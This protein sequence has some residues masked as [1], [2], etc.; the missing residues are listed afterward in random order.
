MSP[1]TPILDD[2][3]ADHTNHYHLV[4]S[5][6]MLCC[7]ILTISS[8]YHTL[9]LPGGHSRGHL[10]HQR[11]WDHCQ[12]LL[13]RIVLGQEKGSKAKTR[14][15]GSIEALLLLTE[16]QPRAL[17]VPSVADG[18]DSDAMLTHK[19]RRDHGGA[20]VANPSRGR[21]LEDVIIPARRFD[22]MS[23]MVL[24]CAM[25]LANELGVFDPETQEDTLTDASCEF[26]RRYSRRRTSIATLLYLYQEHLSSRLGLK[27]MMPQ[28]I[29]HS[30]IPGGSLKSTSYENGEWS[31]FMTA[32]TELT[33]IVR[34][35]TDVLFP[36]PVITKHLLQSGRYISMIEHFRSLL[37]NW[38][39]RY[40]KSPCKHTR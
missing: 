12:N 11:L 27:S 38:E 15:L 14:T 26:D 10:I 29:S 36:S 17:H 16:W 35:I 25:T 30:I 2:F 39:A 28:S 34:S 18:W 20:N 23:S 22:R 8:R 13:M 40:L 5:D 32:S 21:W 6:P 4:A 7:T 3:Y 37:S 19:D 1:L 33:K 24:G 31:S 9:P